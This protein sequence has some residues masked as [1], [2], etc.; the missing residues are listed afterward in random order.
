MNMKV[1]WV[2]SKG[3]ASVYRFGR[4][5]GFRCEIVPIDEMFQTRQDANRD[6]AGKAMSTSLVCSSS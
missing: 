4:V 3:G 1:K 6:M 2:F 5:E